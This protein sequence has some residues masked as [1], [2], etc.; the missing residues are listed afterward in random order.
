ME[1][2]KRTPT[3]GG[4]DVLLR[5]IG[6]NKTVFFVGKGV[7]NKTEYNN[8]LAH[9]ASN[10][11][12]SITEAGYEAQYPKTLD[13]EY[14]EKICKDKGWLKADEKFEDAALSTTP[15]RIGE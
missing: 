5:H 3:R 6:V 2:L 11:E 7:D 15:T 10:I 9:I 1:E 13:R 12:Q 14:V 4:Y 8:R